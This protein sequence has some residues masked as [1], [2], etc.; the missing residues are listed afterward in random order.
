MK[1]IFLFIA[2]AV[3]AGNVF[4]AD[5]VDTARVISSKPVYQRVSDPKQECWVET[6]SST[7]TVTKPAPQEH[8]IGG[9]LLG[10]LVGGVVGNQMG[11]GNGNAIAT[12]AGAVAGALIGDRIAS[13]NQNG[14]EQVTQVPQSREERHCRQIENYKD[15]VSGY[16]VTYRYGGKDVTVRLPNDPGRTVRVGVSVLPDR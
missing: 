6:V 10:G 4:A 5:F 2:T 3:C 8:G 12:G 7:G 11:Q 13:Q 15:V 16:D 14:T 9:A 1:K